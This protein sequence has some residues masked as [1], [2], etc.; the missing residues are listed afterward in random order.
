MIGA[1][2]EPMSRIPGG[3]DF[4]FGRRLAHWPPQSGTRHQSC[5]VRSMHIPEKNRHSESVP[6]CVAASPL[7]RMLAG[8][9]F[10][11]PTARYDPPRQGL[12]QWQG[13]GGQWGDTVGLQQLHSASVQQAGDLL[14]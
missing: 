7:V 14:G 2:H 11:P 5:L 12:D 1:E 3:K 9:F 8:G 10:R 4:G 13:W 6:L